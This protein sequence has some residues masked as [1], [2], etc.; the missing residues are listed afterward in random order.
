MPPTVARA[1]GEASGGAESASA[2]GAAAAAAAAS[3]SESSSNSALVAAAH[4]AAVDNAFLRVRLPPGQNVVFIQVG[5]RLATVDE[6]QRKR[7]FG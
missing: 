6:Q 1:E 2:S 7:V 5:A 4:A 3:A